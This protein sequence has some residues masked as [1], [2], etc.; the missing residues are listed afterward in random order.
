[1][2]LERQKRLNFPLEMQ[3]VTVDYCKNLLYFVWQL[4]LYS[5]SVWITNTVCSLFRYFSIIL[6]AVVCV[7]VSVRLTLITLKPHSH[8][9][10]VR[11]AHPDESAQH[12]MVPHNVLETCK[13]VHI[14]S[15]YTNV[16]MCLHPCSLCVSVRNYTDY[17]GHFCKKYAIVCSIWDIFSFADFTVSIQSN[18]I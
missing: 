4:I 14:C 1:M 10:H 9:A 12:H 13:H 6:L 2:T 8:C 17:C 16:H 7:C 11:S 3:S 5:H 15:A 18:P